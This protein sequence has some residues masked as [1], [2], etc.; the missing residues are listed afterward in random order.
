M[1]KELK[2][3]WGWLKAMYIYTI[4]GAGGVGLGIVVMP[5]GMRSIFGFPS[6]DAIVFG[7]CGSVYVAFGLLSILGLLSPLKFS[8]ISLFQLCYKV[9]WFIGVIL[10]ILFAGKFPN[11]ALI[12]VVVFATYVI[13]DLIAIPFSYV[14]AKQSDR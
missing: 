13:G 1:P 11:Y 8:P 4:I 12:Y 9:V 3:R 14:F 5:D 6:Q 2:V 7:L 10:P